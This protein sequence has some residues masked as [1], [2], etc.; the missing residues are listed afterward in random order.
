MSLLKKNTI[1]NGQI[2][3]NVTELDIG[4]N[5]NRKYKVGAICNNAVYV[6]E[7]AGYLLELYYLV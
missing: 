1:R 3:K 7:S 4:N 6:K 2:D 5:E